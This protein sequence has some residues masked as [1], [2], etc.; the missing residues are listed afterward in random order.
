[1]P[2][3]VKP[4]SDRMA[5][6]GLFGGL[7]VIG[8]VV[9]LFMRGPTPREQRAM[10]EAQRTLTEIEQREANNRYACAH[11]YTAACE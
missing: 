5:I 2:T 3:P 8:L 7:A 6:A 11:G 9:L 4:V 10:D 1:M